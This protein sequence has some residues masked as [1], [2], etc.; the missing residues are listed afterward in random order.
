LI[1]NVFVPDANYSFPKQ[2]GKNG[3]AFR[4]TW[5]AKY[6]WLR[7]SASSDGGYCLPC[8][9]FSRK[10]PLKLQQVSNLVMK[11]IKAC[12]D[13]NSAF[14][15]HEEA[16]DG[17]H[18]FCVDLMTLFLS[19]FSGKSLPISSMVDNMRKQKVQENRALLA[20]LIDTIILCGHLGLPLRGHRDDSFF[21]PEAGEY[22]KTSGVGNFINLIN[23]AIRRGD[24]QLQTHYTS[25]KKNVSYLSK[26]TQNDLI[27]ACGNVIIEDIVSEIRKNKFFSF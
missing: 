6:S 7:Y 4:Y 1:K 19:N 14:K 25:H 23:F 17:L 20:P 13:A 3:R 9:L 27:E 10:A 22:S 24:K 15:R 26:T 5:L 2:Q 18:S 11:P 16:K 8:S 21:H 12:N